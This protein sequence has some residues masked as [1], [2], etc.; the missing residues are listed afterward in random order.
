MVTRFLLIQCFSVFLVDD[1][2]QEKIW[3]GKTTFFAKILWIL[4]KEGVLPEGS[5]IEG[6]VRFVS[7][8]LHN[9]QSYSR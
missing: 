3:K 1:H 9:S 6:T 4:Q 7:F 5:A 2:K 8:F